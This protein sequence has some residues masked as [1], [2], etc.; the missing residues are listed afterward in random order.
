MA[1]ARKALCRDCVCKPAQRINQNFFTVAPAGI[2]SASGGAWSLIRGHPA[3]HSGSEITLPLHLPHG[4]VSAADG[5]IHES[6][7]PMSQSP[8]ATTAHITI[9][10]FQ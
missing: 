3:R 7:S 8:A 2:E 9:Q 5:Q 1:D 6:T 10:N 4:R